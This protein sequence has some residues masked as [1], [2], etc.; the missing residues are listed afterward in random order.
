MIT[1]SAFGKTYTKKREGERKSDRGSQREKKRESKNHEHIF[2]CTKK[3]LID[4][5]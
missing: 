2:N 3:F 4:I 5:P 1:D